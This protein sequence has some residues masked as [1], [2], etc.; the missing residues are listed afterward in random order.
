MAYR[1]AVTAAAQTPLGLGATLGGCPFTILRLS[2]DK[3]LTA[4]ILGWMRTI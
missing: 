4:L 3:Q 1:G 2:G